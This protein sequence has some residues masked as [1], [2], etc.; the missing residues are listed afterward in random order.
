M[1]SRRSDK[2]VQM[3]KFVPSRDVSKLVILLFG[4]Y[5]LLLQVFSEA[6]HEGSLLGH[7]FVLLASI[8]LMDAM[9]LSQLM[10]HFLVIFDFLLSLGPL[11]NELLLPLLIVCLGIL[12]SLLLLLQSLYSALVVIGHVSDLF[13]VPL[14]VSSTCLRVR[15][16]PQLFRGLLLVGLLLLGLL[17]FFVSRSRGLDVLSGFIA[18]D[19]HLNQRVLIVTVF[20]LY[21]LVLVLPLIE[22]GQVQLQLPIHL[23]HRL[24]PNHYQLRLH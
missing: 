13:L 15:N 22:V 6:I 10:Q 11:L 3:V 14:D 17:A 2:G 18:L 16:I 4:L 20:Q 21:L 19:A 24:I 12:Q 23:I 7:F 5:E 9:L 1:Q 8:V